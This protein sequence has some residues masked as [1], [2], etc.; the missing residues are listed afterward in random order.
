VGND[1]V[2]SI[3]FVAGRVVLGLVQRL[4]SEDLLMTTRTE[5]VEERDGVRR[6]TVYEP[7]VKV[8]DEPQWRLT[9]A[10]EVI[11]L[12]ELLVGL[13]EDDAKMAK[14]LAR[15]GLGRWR[16]WRPL[17]KRSPKWLDVPVAERRLIPAL[18]R[19]GAISTIEN[20]V[21]GSDRWTLQSFRTHESAHAALGVQDVEAIRAELRETVTRPELQGWIKQSPEGSM[22]MSTYS[23]MIR[24]ADRW[25]DKYEHKDL[26]R[27]REL[28]AE[29]WNSKALDSPARQRL[30]GR[31]VGRPASELFAT[32][33]RQL[34]AR[35]PLIHDETNLYAHAIGTV[36][37]RPSPRLIGILCVE[38]RTTYDA[39]LPFSDLG[40][41]VMWT[42][43]MPPRAEVELLQRASAMAPGVPVLAAMDPDPGGIEIALSLSARARVNF[44][45]R[46]MS[47]D[48]LMQATQLD[49]EPWD[50]AR[51]ASLE[52]RAGL[53]KP[54]LKALRTVDGKGEQES[55]H[56]WLRRELELAAGGQRP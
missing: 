20:P 40:W 24:I 43:G 15:E 11:D 34:D 39:L 27:R 13:S 21:R 19:A 52:S 3:G 16:Q 49:L 25:L 36:R 47:P 5:V 33:P 29:M 35:G 54:L 37:L 8:P 28:A 9:N 53:H 51:M 45:V 7:R 23:H 12:D 2:T 56:P 48:A 41:L 4:F 18:M 22:R 1:A 32:A 14:R 42:R 44:D 55:F 10:L 50:R 31:M 17:M 30:L 46:L 6:A 38:N 26:P